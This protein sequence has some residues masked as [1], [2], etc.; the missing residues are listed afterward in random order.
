MAPSATKWRSALRALNINECALHIGSSARARL[1]LD[2]CLLSCG[3]MLMYRISCAYSRAHKWRSIPYTR[4]QSKRPFRV[5]AR[6][7]AVFT[8]NFNTSQ[9]P[10]T[11][12]TGTCRITHTVH[13][14][15]VHLS[16]NAH[17]KKPKRERRLEWM[18]RCQVTFHTPNTHLHVSMWCSVERPSRTSCT[19]EHIQL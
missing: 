17:T 12:T 14:C 4:A 7:V 8:R 9:S 3:L 1:S 15:N 5:V 19:V 6:A 2:V 13:V 10:E 18:W 11:S 16:K